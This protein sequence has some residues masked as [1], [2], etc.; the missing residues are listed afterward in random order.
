MR[1]LID[2]NLA[3]DVD[4]LLGALA[5]TGWLELVSIRFV[6]FG[7]V[8]LPDKIDDRTLWRFVQANDMLLLT[9]N[10][11]MKGP[12]SL[13]Q[14]IREENTPRSYPVVTISRRDH[15]DQRDYRRR[16]AERLAEI[17][18]DLERYRGVSRIF[19]P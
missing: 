2:R 19:I 18:I 4:L 6:T 16:C 5:A 8:N 3:G 13:E 10:R 7:E 9:E 15:L 12:D 14:T 11:N 17:V 1:F